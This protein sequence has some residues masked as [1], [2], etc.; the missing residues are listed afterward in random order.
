MSVIEKF[1]QYDRELDLHGDNS[2]MYLVEITEGL[3]LLEEL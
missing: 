2:F 3:D 1:A